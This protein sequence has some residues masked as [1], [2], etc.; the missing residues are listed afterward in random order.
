MRAA[1][2]FSDFGQRARAGKRADYSW[3]RTGVRSL[4]AEPPPA[5]RTG[6]INVRA[7]FEIE[8]DRKVPYK[9][10]PAPGFGDRIRALLGDAYGYY[11]DDDEE[12]E[13]DDDDESGSCSTCGGRDYMW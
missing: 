11:D 2:R 1:G 10:R 12:D 3:L 4:A 9:H 5:A 7:V 8:D 13:D 6:R